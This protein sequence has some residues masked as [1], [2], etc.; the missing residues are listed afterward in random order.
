MNNDT[1]TDR[2]LFRDKRLRYTSVH[3][4]KGSKTHHNRNNIKCNTRKN[5][6]QQAADS[7]TYIIRPPEDG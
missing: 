4:L 1:P 2:T 3:Q 5:E 6:K 7:L